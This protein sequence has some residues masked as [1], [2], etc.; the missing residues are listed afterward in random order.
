ME[1]A[2]LPPQLKCQ[3][4]TMAACLFDL[5]LNLPVH[6]EMKCDL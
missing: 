2:L 6:C 3:E 4:M 5:N 1:K